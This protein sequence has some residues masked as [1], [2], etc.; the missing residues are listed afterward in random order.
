MEDSATGPAD[1]APTLTTR[2]LAARTRATGTLAA[3]TRATGTLA[4]RTRTTR[5]LPTVTLAALVDVRRAETTRRQQ[6]I[7]AQH[8]VDENNGQREGTYRPQE[9]SG[10]RRQAN[11]AG[12]S[13]GWLGE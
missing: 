7:G 5:S 13:T 2:T 6:R 12:G 4:A 3:R 1:T 9:R 10:Q 8:A 11:S